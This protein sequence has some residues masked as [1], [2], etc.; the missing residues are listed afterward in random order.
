MVSGTLHV[1]Y[2]IGFAMQQI[3][4]KILNNITWQKNNQPPNLVVDI[5]HIALKLLSGQLKY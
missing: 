1:I 2:S 4:M 5:L 3:N